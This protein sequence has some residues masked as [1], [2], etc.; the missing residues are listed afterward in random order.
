MLLSVAQVYGLDTSPTASS[1]GVVK[2]LS[3]VVLKK[4]F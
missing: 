1:V 3:K 4:W 2:L